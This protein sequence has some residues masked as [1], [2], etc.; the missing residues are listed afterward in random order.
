MPS[1]GSTQSNALG[2]GVADLRAR[3][4]E[5]QITGGELKSL[6]KVAALM[7]DGSGRISGDDL[8]AASFAND[9]P[10]QDAVAD[11]ADN[12]QTL[13]F[14]R[15]SNQGRRR[16]GGNGSSS[17]KD[18]RYRTLQR[19]VGK[20][21]DGSSRQSWCGGR[22]V[23]LLGRVCCGLRNRPSGTNA[24]A[25]SSGRHGLWQHCW[26]AARTAGD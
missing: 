15:R 14:P 10:H 17:L 7:D 13:R 21:G 9:L 16:P 6:Q 3:M 26:R 1:G 19:R 8:I 12:Q 18:R 24:I 20:F 2:V 4:Q 25:D 11:Q 23:G 22:R 5:A